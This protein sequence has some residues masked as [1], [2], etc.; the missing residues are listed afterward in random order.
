MHTGQT[1]WSVRCLAGALAICGAGW[2][3]AAP[4]HAAD[5]PD[6]IFKKSTVFKWLS[7]N[8]KLATYGLDDPVIEGV[9][10]QFTVASTP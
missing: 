2:L 5:E 3:A 4:A 9:A 6:L 10:C 8:D 1:R 7:P